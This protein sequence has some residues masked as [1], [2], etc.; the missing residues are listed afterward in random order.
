MTS[1][2]VQFILS[3][4]FALSNQMSHYIAEKRESR[5][6]GFPTRTDTHL[7]VQSQKEVRIL[8]FWIEVEE[9]L[10]NMSSKHKGKYQLCSYSLFASLFLNR[11]KS[12]FLMMRLICRCIKIIFTDNSILTQ[13]FIVW[14]YTIFSCVVLQS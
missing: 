8:K 5:S 6:S 7:P 4:I 2:F 1:G 11:Q 14:L 3:Q 10:Y 9:K 12:S 13:L